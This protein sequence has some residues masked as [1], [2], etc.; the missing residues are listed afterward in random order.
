MSNI[1]FV[2]SLTPEQ[3]YK[4]I[5]FNEDIEFMVGVIKDK[6]RLSICDSKENFRMD[7]TWI[8]NKWKADY[9]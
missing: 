7:Y 1:E 5:D 6:G 8:N 4:F 2:L 9:E 3:I